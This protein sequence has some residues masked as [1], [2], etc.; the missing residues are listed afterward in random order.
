MIR[1][2]ATSFH[3]SHATLLQDA[4]GGAALAVMFVVMLLLPGVF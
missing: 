2:I 3:R 4:I 1:Q